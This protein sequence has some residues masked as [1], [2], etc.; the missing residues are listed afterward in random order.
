MLFKT[1]QPADLGFV[2]LVAIIRLLPGLVQYGI[3]SAV[4]VTVGIASTVAGFGLSLAA[5]RF[6]ALLWN[7]SEQTSWV[8]A[9]KTVLLSLV[10]TSVT[11]AFYLAISPLLSI[12]FTKSTSWTWAFLLGGAWIFSVSISNTFQG[13][14]QGL[15]K[16]VQLAKIIFVT[17]LVMVVASTAI[18][19]FDRTI[20][21]PLLAWVLFYSLDHSLDLYDCREEAHD[22]NRVIQLFNN[23]TLRYAVRRRWN[24]SGFRH[25]VR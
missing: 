17:R 12:Y 10:L 23:L 18:L 5:T 24:H 1:S 25:L 8:V 14:L 15:K 19:Y 20:A 16:Y 7:D 22:C 13:I 3:Y 11:T 2:F 4:L 9:R 21:V 6:V